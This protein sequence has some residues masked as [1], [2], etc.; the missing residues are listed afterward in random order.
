MSESPGH[1][2]C[3]DVDYRGESAQV[4][5]IA[6]ADWGSDA[7]ADTQVFTMPT[8]GEYVPGEFY[9][10]ELPCILEALKRFQCAIDTILVDSYVWLPG[11]PG[12]GA[13]LYEALDQQVTVIGVAKTPFQDETEAIAI[14]RGES[15]RP[16]Y[17]T[18]AGISAQV[19]ADQVKRM[20]GPHRIPTLL[21]QVDSL[22][23]DHTSARVARLISQTFSQEL[24]DQQG[25]Y[26]GSYPWLPGAL[27]GSASTFPFSWSS[28]ICRA[29]GEGPARSDCLASGFNSRLRVRPSQRLYCPIQGSK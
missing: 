23:R 17:I 5:A 9:K 22:C 6:F 20:H 25:L 27:P 28:S 13:H 19:A 29:G 24:A 21:K 26:R 10:R 3:V 18:A 15:Q 14:L 1:K 2:L 16:L 4:A 7:A 8:P 12:M 11:R